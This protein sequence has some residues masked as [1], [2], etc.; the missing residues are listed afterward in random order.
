MWF[1]LSLAALICWSGSDL[2]SKLG[3]QD[4]R[5]KYSHLKM[6]MNYLLG[7]IL[8]MI[9]FS[10]SAGFTYPVIA[11]FMA[12]CPY[13]SADGLQV[14][15]RF[16]RIDGTDIRF[17]G[18]VTDTLGDGGTHNIVLKR[19]GKLVTLSG[20]DM[21]ERHAGDDAHLHDSAGEKPHGI[22]KSLRDGLPVLSQVFPQDP[23]HP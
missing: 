13:E 3:C 9:V 22:K 21:V 23:H 10:Q 19:D 8:L 12:G 18:Q 5:D 7:V 1:W 6:V 16:V 11:S 15:D 2:F 20:Y 17:A 14:G 4:A